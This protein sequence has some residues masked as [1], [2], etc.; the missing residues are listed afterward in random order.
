MSI[1]V[2]DN[3]YDE[4]TEEKKIESVAVYARKSRAEEGE[5]DL[6]NHLIRLKARCELNQWDYEV[7][8]E[9]GSGGS[10]EERPQMMQLLSDVGT[11]QYDAVVVVD[12]DRL[13]RGKG[14]DLDRILGT[15][16]NN[17][18]K[19]VQES[20]YEVYDLT[21]SSHAQMLEMKMFFGNME[22]MQTK[23]RFREG[24]RLSQ[25]LGKWVHG[26]APFGYEIDK[27]TKRLVIQN[28]EAAT[29]ELMKQLFFEGYNTVDIAWEL[30]KNGHVKRSGNQFESKSI[31]RILKNEVY[32]GTTVYNKTKGN[33]KQNSNLYSSGL[34]FR[35][36][37]KSEWK[38]KYNTHPA[39]ISMEEHKQIIEH[40]QSNKYLSKSKSRNVHS[41]SGLC[42]TPEGE[43][44]SIGNY[45]RKTGKPKSIHIQRNKYEEKSKY[46]QVP[47]TMVQQV[48]V[49]SLKVLEDEL[50]ELLE[51]NNNDREIKQL[52][53]KAL[54]LKSEVSKLES[55]TEKIQEGFLAGLFDVMEAKQIKEKKNKEI[56]Q[57]ENE[58]LEVN[59]AIDK[60]SSSTNISRL[61]RL[62]NI[63]K[64]IETETKSKELNDLYKSIINN[65]IVSRIDYDE[66]DIQVNFL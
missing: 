5:K 49:E 26:Q 1:D 12:I 35:R 52:E 34:P 17:N 45:D 2:M 50:A 33:Y 55:E 15:F 24:K 38:R 36:L 32:T 56:D 31:S 54:K 30:N 47:I 13:S 63:Y 7:Y 42:F 21:N 57:K 64:Q 39:L 59:K 25:H 51:D 66:V 62:R 53:N 19:I 3:Y 10:L 23:K 20:P 58:L 65:I 46:K 22:L 4:I 6:K 28:E 8:K 43:S 40:F 18:V 27:K 44:Y 37:D 48:I 60:L 61:D 14:A 9:I 16:R 29:L 41:L 11:G